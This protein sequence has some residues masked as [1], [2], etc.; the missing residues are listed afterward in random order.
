MFR[1]DLEFG[2][3]SD[4]VCQ[5]KYVWAGECVLYVIVAKGAWTLLGRGDLVQCPET[6][7]TVGC[8]WRCSMALR[9]VTNLSYVP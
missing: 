3:F 6:E 5:H 7:G 1:V 9:D 8:R 2:G 4:V